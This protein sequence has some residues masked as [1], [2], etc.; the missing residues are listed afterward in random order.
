MDYPSHG[1]TYSGVTFSGPTPAGF[2]YPICAAFDGAA[3][4]VRLE[5]TSYPFGLARW[6]IS[7]WFKKTGAGVATVTAGGTDGF[8]TADPIV[9]LVTKG[10]GE[11]DGSNVD[12]NWHLGLNKVNNGS[13]YRLAGDFEDM[14]S[15]ANH[16]I[17]GTSDI[18]DG[19]WYHG[20]FTF[21]GAQMKLFLNGALEAT[22]ASSAPL[23]N[24]FI[25]APSNVNTP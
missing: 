2:K 17:V 23:R 6:T 10:R 8:P 13:T 3:S 21:D 1:Y 18:V 9:P 14:A 19:Q 7:C 16:R 11:A 24:S 22:V 12:A 25:C 20:V 15:G 5:N 4:Q